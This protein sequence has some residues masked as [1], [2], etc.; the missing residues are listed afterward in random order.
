[1][2]SHGGGTVPGSGRGV[3]DGVGIGAFGVVVSATDGTV[4]LGPGSAEAPHPATTT[5]A[6]TSSTATE[7][8]DLTPRRYDRVPR[9]ITGE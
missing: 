7:S 6:A 8:F 9:L 4:P 5:A 1:M 2:P 3:A